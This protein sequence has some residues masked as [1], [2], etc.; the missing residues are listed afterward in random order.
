MSIC[1]SIQ[2]VGN[3]LIDAFST[4]FGC[5]SG[6]S[7]NA[8]WYPKGEF[9]GVGF[10][11]LFS[12]L[13]ASGKIIINR[14]FKG[15]FQLIDSFTVEG[16]NISNAYQATE[17]T[18]SSASKSIRAVYPLY[19][20]AFF[21]ATLLSVLENRQ[22]R[23]WYRK[24]SLPG[25]GRWK[26]AF[27]PLRTIVILEALPL[28]TSHPTALNRASILRHL[29]FPDT[30]RKIGRSKSFC[31]FGSCNKIISVFATMS[32]KIPAENAG[33]LAKTLQSSVSLEP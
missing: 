29:I 7:V 12:Q 14:R 23:T 21:M 11:R 13:G 25:W 17:N 24:A 10:V 9:A 30:G 8:R 20:M 27:R 1:G 16:D 5:G 18:R 26:A 19:V 28:I 2:Y 22:A 3:P 31:G 15:C 33:Y 6:C 32:R 4:G